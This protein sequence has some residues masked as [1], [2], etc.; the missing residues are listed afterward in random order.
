MTSQPLEQLIAIS[1]KVGANKSLVL[2]NYG[3]TSVKT[4]DG[5]FMYVKAS[6]AELGKM[7][8]RRGWR[9]VHL[10]RILDI[11]DDRTLAELNVDKQKKAIDIALLKACLDKKP[12]SVMPSI[13]TFFHAL[14]GPVVV[15]LIRTGGSVRQ[16]R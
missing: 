8:S 2:G 6:G 11:L 3:N 12:A 4:A 9:K 5:R 7:T 10:Q 13:E 14:L 16:K 1:R 15:H